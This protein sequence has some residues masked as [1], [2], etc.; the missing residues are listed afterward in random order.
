MARTTDQNSATSGFFIN[1]DNNTGWNSD[2]NPYA[3]FGRLVSGFAVASAIAKLSGT[4]GS[5]G[6][7]T[8]DQPAVVMWAI[9]LK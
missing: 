1:L 8:P 4:V 2:A 9:Q 3:A 7:V 6:T 5:D